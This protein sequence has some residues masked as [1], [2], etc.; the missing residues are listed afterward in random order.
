MQ[1]KK[2][3]K[4]S[5]FAHTLT[6]LPSVEFSAKPSAIELLLRN[7]PPNPPKSFI[8]NDSQNR[9]K[10]NFEIKKK[11]KV[12]ECALKNTQDSFFFFPHQSPYEQIGVEKKKEK[13]ERERFFGGKAE[14]SRL[15]EIIL[16]SVM[17][18][19]YELNYHG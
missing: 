17:C 15:N 5:L 12:Q 2:K 10:T 16:R 8:P 13:K 1:K 9:L 19:L 11:K 18:L 7:P 14:F 4:E 3:E 6:R